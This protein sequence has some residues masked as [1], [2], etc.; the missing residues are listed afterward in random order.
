LRQACDRSVSPGVVFLS[1]LLLFARTS[2]RCTSPVLLLG[3][4]G[5]PATAPKDS[6]PPTC[7]AELP[8]DA[9]EDDAGGV[10]F[11]GQGRPGE[12]R[13]GGRGLRAHAGGGAAA[14]PRWPI[15]TSS[16]P[17]EPESRSGGGGK[18]RQARR[19]SSARRAGRCC[20]STQAPAATACAS[21]APLAPTSARSRT[22][23]SR[24]LAPFIFLRVLVPRSSRVYSN[25]WCR[26]L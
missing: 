4:E 22:R 13:R 12:A 7:R 10:P 5:R 18:G 24:R 3:L 2:H 1:S 20:R 21:S 16:W 15:R 23:F 8:A 17:N 19:W 11:Q 25:L 14:D 9:Q 6:P 26:R